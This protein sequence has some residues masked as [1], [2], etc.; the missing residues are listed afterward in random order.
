LY[1]K[2]RKIST[3]NWRYFIQ[4]YKEIHLVCS[5]QFQRR[6]YIDWNY[7]YQHKMF[8]YYL[9][10]KQYIS[11]QIYIKHLLLSILILLLFV[12]K[13]LVYPHHKRKQ[14]IHLLS[15]LSNWNFAISSVNILPIF[16]EIASGQADCVLVVF[17]FF[18]EGIS[19]EAIQGWG[20]NL[21]IS[22]DVVQNTL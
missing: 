2:R 5:C 8:C 15:F 22:F 4:R 13:F 14:K 1:T 12:Y 16:L 7:E 9:L 6:N 20:I 17:G 21:C 11:Y 10:W 18:T 3:L 19:I